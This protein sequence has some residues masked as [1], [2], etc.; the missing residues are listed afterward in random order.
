MCAPEPRRCL[1]LLTLLVLTGCGCPRE[2]GRAAPGPADGAPCLLERLYL[3]RSSP[4]GPVSEA[5]FASFLAEVVTP[6][7]PDGL[8]RLDGS[9][10]WRDDAGRIAHEPTT[11]LEIAT[12][13][14]PAHR[15]AVDAIS[16]AYCR[17]FHQQAVLVVV[18]PGRMRL[19][20]ATG[21]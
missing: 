10:Q 5:D 3:G 18:L 9:G 6:R 14:T 15:A 8:T 2:A 21:P 7:F 12:P 20:T 13:D 17:R 11:V 19:P 1:P 16:A 4:Q